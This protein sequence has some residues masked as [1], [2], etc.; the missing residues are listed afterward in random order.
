MERFIMIN[1]KPTNY[2]AT[3]S[4]LIFDA[5]NCRLIGQYQNN[6][7]YFYVGLKY[8][9]EQHRYFVHRII[10]E[11]FVPNDDPEHKLVVNH[12][13]GDKTDNRA[14]NLEWVT[15]GENNKHAYRNGF[16][17]PL[18][19]EQ[20]VFTKYTREQVTKACE[21]LQDGMSPIEVS[22]AT[23]IQ[24][25]NL[26]DIRNGRLWKDVTCNYTFPKSKYPR[27]DKYDPK[28]RN[29]VETMIKQGYSNAYIRDTLNIPHLYKHIQDWKYRMKKAGEI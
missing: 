19:A 24:V 23:G 29:Q 13:N 12:I 9:G 16:R 4:G 18:K 15:Y 6:A 22:K 10:A 5:M 21:L 2:V 25:K 1:G 20:V 14:E 3:D 26:Y 8:N 28:L 7:G 11:L 27:S 17:K